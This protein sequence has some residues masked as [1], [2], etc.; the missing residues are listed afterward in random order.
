MSRT[1]DNKRYIALLH[2]IKQR[3]YK[4]QYAALKAVNKEL[5]SL[6]W[7]IGRLIVERQK[8]YGWGRSIVENLAR[9]LQL[10]F[11]GILGFSTQNL[12]YMRQF[13]LEYSHNAKL[14]PLVGEIS[15]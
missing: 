6:Y 15:W 12:W 3:V 8:E 13:Y 10:E 1:I 5:I 4:A 11:P 7:D 2:E 9:D 14:Q